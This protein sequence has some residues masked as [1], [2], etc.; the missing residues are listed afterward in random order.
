MTPTP[1]PAGV[2]LEDC[3]AYVKSAERFTRSESETGVYKAILASLKRLAV[4][5]AVPE[6]CTE[7]GDYIREQEKDPVRAKA[8]AEAR[9]RLKAAI[10][11]VKV[12][13]PVERYTQNGSGMVPTFQTQ[14][15]G[16]RKPS[17]DWM[18]SADYDT[19][20]TRL[21]RETERADRA[22]A[23]LAIY[24]KRYAP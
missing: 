11:S 5:D 17:G 7:I 9:I 2:T 10:D 8:L 16:T 20:I 21:Q 14:A 24:E 15:D 3:I 23:K 4:I 19:L 22:E 12:P 13:E 18:A 6:G 1:T